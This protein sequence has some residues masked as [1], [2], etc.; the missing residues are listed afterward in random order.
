MWFEKQNLVNSHLTD[1]SYGLRTQSFILESL[2]LK[3]GQGEFP[4]VTLTIELRVMPIIT[5]KY[6]TS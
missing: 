3:M 1:L 5:G 6:S 2:K 4:L